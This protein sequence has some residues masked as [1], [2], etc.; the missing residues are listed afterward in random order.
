MQPAHFQAG[1]RPLLRC[2]GTAQR[3]ERW[4]I[5]DKERLNAKAELILQFTI[6]KQVN[7]LRRYRQKLRWAITKL[8]SLLRRSF[9]RPRIT[10]RFV[11]MDF[12]RHWGT[13][14]CNDQPFIVIVTQ[15]WVT[16]ASGSGTPVR[17]L[18]ARPLGSLAKSFI[19]ADAM[20]GRREHPRWR[21]LQFRKETH[22]R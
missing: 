11:A 14:S 5:I 12:P 1:G 6:T 4:A 3:G 2:M 13:G 10:L 7:R 21:R 9:K 8:W 22:E 19:G 18:K 20:G 15:R 17:V 16:N